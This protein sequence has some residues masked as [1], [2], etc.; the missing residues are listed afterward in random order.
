MT[1][2]EARIAAANRAA[3]RAERMDSILH[4]NQVGR[5]YRLAWPRSTQPLLTPLPFGHT[6][7]VD[8]GTWGWIV[9]QRQGQSLQRTEEAMRRLGA[10][11]DR[12]ESASAR[13]GAGD[14]LLAGE[15]R[16]ARDD[17]AK[18]EETTRVVSTRLDATIDRLRDLL[19][20]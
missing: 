1:A 6:F 12:L 2:G 18:L 7:D 9:E 8:S 16:G 3:F 17:Y 11:I 15:L 5:G 19:E 13:V 4:E 14:L 20:D 10:A